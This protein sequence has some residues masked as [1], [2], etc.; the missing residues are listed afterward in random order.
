MS[1]I[2][3]LT[4]VVAA[5]LALGARAWSH[6]REPLQLVGIKG[7]LNSLVDILGEN[8]LGVLPVSVRHAHTLDLAL[9]LLALNTFRN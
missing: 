8:G 1:R 4:E 6:V 5:A 7:V 3:H 9:I 2:S